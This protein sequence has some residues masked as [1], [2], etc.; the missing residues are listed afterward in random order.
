MK[1]LRAFV[2]VLFGVVL[3]LGLVLSILTWLQIHDVTALYG[4]LVIFNAVG[5][6][7]FVFMGL[8]QETAILKPLSWKR[9]SLYTLAVAVG[10]FGILTFFLLHWGQGNAIAAFG[11]LVPFVVPS[12]A[13]I[14]FL[15]L[16]EKSRIKG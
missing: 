6:C 15:T 5:I 14:T 8:T 13:I 2:Y 9:A 16:T 1:S 12:L 3:A 11:A 4:V 7:G 10:L